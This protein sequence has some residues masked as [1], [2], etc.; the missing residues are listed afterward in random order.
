VS[1][2]LFQ[3]AWWSV[4]GSTSIE[5]IGA[6]LLP[7]KSRVFWIYVE[8]DGNQEVEYS[9]AGTAGH[10]VTDVRF[11]QLLFAKNGKDFGVEVCS[12]PPCEIITPL[13]DLP[14][15]PH[16]FA[17]AYNGSPQAWDSLA[18]FHPEGR[19]LDRKNPQQARELVERHLQAVTHKPHRPA[20]K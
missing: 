7:D 16:L 20:T 12:E 15:L 17:A 4:R 13:K 14:E 19:F 3:F 18:P 1:Y 11:L 2:Q 10:D 8:G 6:I 9:I 5:Q